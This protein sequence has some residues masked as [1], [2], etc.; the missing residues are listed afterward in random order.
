MPAI[1]TAAET[2][3]PREPTTFAISFAI[4]RE[5]RQRTAA[6]NLTSPLPEPAS[7]EPHRKRRDFSE[8]VCAPVLVCFARQTNR[9]IRG[10]RELV[11][12]RLT[13]LEQPRSFDASL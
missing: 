7:T 13:S 10:L 3:A 4:H 9:S 8:T 5:D 2:L 12:Q 6:Q 1:S 11:W